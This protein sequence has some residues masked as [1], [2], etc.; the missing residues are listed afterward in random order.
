[1][2]IRRVNLSGDVVVP[3]DSNRTAAEDSHRC[4]TPHIFSTASFLQVMQAMGKCLHVGY[5]S[6][7]AFLSV[8]PFSH[9]GGISSSLAVTMVAGCHV[10]LPH[11]TPA[12]GS[13]AVQ[14]GCI[15]TLVVVPTMLHMILNA[16]HGSSTDEEH[17]AVMTASPSPLAGVKTVLVGG[18]PLSR[19]LECLARARMPEARF[20]QTYACTEAGST[21]TFWSSPVVSQDPLRGASPAE[22][23]SLCDTVSAEFGGMPAAN[24][25]VR[26]V[27]KMLPNT[28][29]ARCCAPGV[30]GEIETRG[31]H[32]MKGYW[33]R[34]ELTNEVIRLDGW[35]RTG[36]L[37]R[38]DERSG[39]LVFVGRMKD[40]I[41]TGGENVH[42]SEVESV[43]LRHAWVVEAVAYGVEDERLGEKVAASV[44]LGDAAYDDAGA[45]SAGKAR[46]VLTDFCRLHLS[47]YKQP[48][49]IQIVPALPRNSAGKVLRHRL[50]SSL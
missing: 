24:V 45:V 15:N 31:P 5:T 37:G 3:R 2:S 41:K 21:I 29:T 4:C 7:T 8:V 9:V 20:I 44:V 30:V 27:E 40:M 35:L 22:F 26:V 48:R 11:F 14:L 32:V 34:P 28:A 16:S 6:S 50:R 23:T 18:Q 25:E 49:H 13:S 19:R 43:L 17:A 12:S 42:A 38:L 47:H 1:M 10:F 33:G 46:T 39:H 36:D